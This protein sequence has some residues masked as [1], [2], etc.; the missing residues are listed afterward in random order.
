MNR[1]VSI[2]YLVRAPDDAENVRRPAGSFCMKC[3]VASSQTWE[4]V[5][6]IRPSG[7]TEV[8]SRR[9]AAR[10]ASRDVEQQ[11]LTLGLLLGRVRTPGRTQ[12][13]LAHQNITTR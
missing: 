9:R 11:A 5:D 2:D 4:L 10:D 1:N 3:V 13:G 7:Q 8:D 6:H 12:V